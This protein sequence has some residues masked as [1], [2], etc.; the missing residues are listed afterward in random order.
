ML[1]KD[2]MSKKVVTIDLNS[3]MQKASELMVHHGISM[4][5]VMEDGKL[6]GVVTDRDLKRAAPSHVT[7]MEVKH[8][9]YNMMQVEMSSIMSKPVM[10]VPLDYTVEEAAELLMRHKI[11]GCPVVDSQGALVGVI[12]KNDLFRAMIS[13]TGLTK[14]GVQFGFLV[15]DKPGSIRAVADT[16]RN[17]NGR[18]VS[19]MST[20]DGAPEGSRKVY[21]RAFNVDHDHLKELTEELRKVATIYYMVDHKMGAREVYEV[22]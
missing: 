9:L 5:P 6:V 17:R 16:I 22:P 11:S 1:V 20:Y 13:V 7:V 15:E 18:V 8:I 21:V 2:W 3:N 4:L 19:I 12:T 14:R 10:T